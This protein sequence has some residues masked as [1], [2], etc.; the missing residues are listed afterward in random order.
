[1]M[2]GLTIDFTSDAYDRI[3]YGSYAGT[4]KKILED[5]PLKKHEYSVSGTGVWNHYFEPVSN[6]D[7]SCPDKP[8]LHLH[9]FHLTPGMLMYCPWSIKSWPYEGL[10]RKLVPKTTLQQW[11]RPMRQKG[12]EIVQKYVRFRPNIRQAAEDMV[13][14][15]FCLAM[16]IRHSDKAG[17][18]RKR[19]PL[20][21][22]LPYAQAYVQAGGKTVVL[23][24]DSADVL[25]RIDKEWPPDITQ[26]IV[27]Q[28]GDVLRSSDRKAVF[29]LGDT[30]HDRTNREVL[31]DILAMSKCRFFVHGFSAVSEAVM[32][33]NFDLHHHSVD[34][35]EHPLNRRKSPEEFRRLVNDTLRVTRK[36]TDPGKKRIVT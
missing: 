25:T 6:F 11:Y 33:L 19:I 23:A 16:H 22:F 28:S 2:Q 14:D 35:E 18:K 34:L 36:V 21:A 29:V 12:S 27:R 15:T 13:K 9:Y 17:T 8:L 31:I 1:M 26:T 20:E 4:P 7:F 30:T 3:G 32:Y 24:T 10:V 5:Q